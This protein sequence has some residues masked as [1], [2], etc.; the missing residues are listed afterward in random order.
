VGFLEPGQSNP[1]WV[2]AGNTVSVERRYTISA[3]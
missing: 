1:W 3:T 2:E